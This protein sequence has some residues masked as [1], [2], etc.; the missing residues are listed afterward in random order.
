MTLIGEDDN[1]PGWK[2]N[3]KLL[4]NNPKIHIEYGEDNTGNINSYI[5]KRR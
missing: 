1:I 2:K 3:P 4:K 5:N